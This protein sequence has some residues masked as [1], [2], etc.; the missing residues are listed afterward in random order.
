MTTPARGT[1]RPA[2][3]RGGRVHSRAYFYVIYHDGN[4]KAAVG[5]LAK[6]LGPV[7]RIAEEF[8]GIWYSNYCEMGQKDSE[9]ITDDFERYSLPLD[10]ISVDMDWHGQDWY[11]YE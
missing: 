5:E 4:W 6:L 2:G 10:I 11:G 9:A 1:P 7:P 3:S 8:M